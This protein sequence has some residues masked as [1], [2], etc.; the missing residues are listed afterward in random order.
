MSWTGGELCVEPAA[1]A[2]QSNILHFEWE[3]VGKTNV[4]Y[5]WIFDLVTKVVAE[6]Q[7]FPWIY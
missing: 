3:I 2:E 1:G 5:T 7:L 4:L 6:D